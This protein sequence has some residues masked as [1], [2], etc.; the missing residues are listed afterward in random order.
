M[1]TI[2]VTAL[3]PGLHSVE[4][5]PAPEDLGLDPSA[6]ADVYVEARLE[7]A[8]ERVFA[9]VRAKALAVLTCD[10]TLVEFRQPI[11]GEH[12]IL[13]LP[14]EQTNRESPAEDDIRALPEPGAPLDVT[15]AV[16]D[17]LLLS[18]PVRRIAPGA[19][20]EEIQTV[21]GEGAEDVADPRWDALRRLRD[22]S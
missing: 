18:I 7:V 12:A 8:A 21:F 11:G 3:K 19:E 20:D 2:D 22:D 15:E 16:R 6:F 14:I 5:E 9:V 1:V 4:L 17:T 10:R 13:F